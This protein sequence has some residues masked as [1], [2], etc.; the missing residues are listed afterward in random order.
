MKKALKGTWFF[1][2]ALL[3]NGTWSMEAQAIDC[4]QVRAALDIGSGTTKMVVARV[5]FC[6]NHVL[7]ILAPVPGF[8][9]ERQVE[10]QKN[11]VTMPG[12]RKFFSD[13][14]IAQGLAAI[15]ELKTVALIHGAEAFSAVA[16]SAFRSVGL[17]Q[18]LALLERIREETG[19]RAVVISQDQEARLGFLAAAIN[20]GLPQENLVVWDIGGGSM[21]ISYWNPTTPGSVAGYRGNFANEAMQ[22][23]IIETLQGK[24]YPETKSPNPMLRPDTMIDQPNDLSRAIRD[25]EKAAS[26]EVPAGLR[27][28]LRAPTTQVIG[29]GGVHFNSNC[30]FLRR[31]S[32]DGCEF[33]RQEL[34]DQAYRYAHLTDQELFMEGLSASLAFAKGRVSGAALTLGFM[35]ALG[36]DRVRAIKVDMGDGILIDQEFWARPEEQAREAALAVTPQISRQRSFS[37]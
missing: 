25:A 28:K 9:L 36:I 37:R 35:N 13:E 18:A 12:G 5:D 26:Q 23:F 16:T 19:F 14:V 27:D 11:I 24:D 8:K 4:E 10:Y 2:F 20:A 32:S 31:F 17:T 29:I 1:A 3:L 6:E 15:L 34:L 30:E 7:E 22:R 21:Q 33:T